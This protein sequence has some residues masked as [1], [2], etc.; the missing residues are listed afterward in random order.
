MWQN[1][2]LDKA[3]LVCPTEGKQSANG[4]VYNSYIGGKAMAE[5]GDP[6][7]TECSGDGKG[8]YNGKKPNIA[9]TVKDFAPRHL[10]KMILSYLDGH[11]ALAEAPSDINFAQP[12]EWFDP[13]LYDTSS[14]IVLHVS[15]AE[16]WDRK[17]PDWAC[18]NDWPPVEADIRPAIYADISLML[19]QHNYTGYYLAVAL[20]VV[21]IKEYAASGVISLLD[22]ER[23]SLCIACGFDDGEL[24][25]IGELFDDG[26]QPLDGP[27]IWAP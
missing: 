20:L 24:Y 4:Y 19:S 5:V 2:K 8:G 6:V 27:G 3:T 26:M 21:M 15:G 17:N 14:G 22:D 1:I 11:V 9:Y 23:Q 12:S 10:N 13:V 16:A 18:R 7:N 25:N